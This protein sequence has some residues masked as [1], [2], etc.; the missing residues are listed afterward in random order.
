MRSCLSPGE[1]TRDRIILNV[2]SD[3]CL[4]QQME[5]LLGDARMFCF[6]DEGRQVENVWRGFKCDTKVEAAV[7]CFNKLLTNTPRLQVYVLCHPPSVHMCVCVCM[8]VSMH[9]CI[10]TYIHTHT[11]TRTHAHTHARTH[12]R[13]HAH[14]HTCFCVFLQDD[15]HIGH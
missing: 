3:H 9:A 11:H 5:Y 6:S 2:W 4:V 7:N 8:T 15:L 14:T 12:T 13:T 10:L 1:G